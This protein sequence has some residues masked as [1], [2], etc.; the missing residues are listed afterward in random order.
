MLTGSIT[1]AAVAGDPDKWHIRLPR[2]VQ[3]RQAQLHRPQP[4]PCPTDRA[5]LYHGGLQEDKASSGL[6]ACVCV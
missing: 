6:P 2:P 4:V 5:D 1:L 3:H